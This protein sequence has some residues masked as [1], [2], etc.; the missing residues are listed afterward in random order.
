[1]AFE[2]GVRAPVTVPARLPQHGLAG[3]I[4]RGEDVPVD[5]RAVH[6]F[7]ANDLARDVGDAVQRPAREIVPVA[8]AMERRID[9]GAG[10]RDHVYATYLELRAFG[11]DAARSLA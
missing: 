8:I 10:V 7:H 2:I 9:I 5:G 11:I 6:A 3:D 4:G 1:M